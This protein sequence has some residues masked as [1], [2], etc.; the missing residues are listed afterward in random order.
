MVGHRT[1]L[2]VRRVLSNCAVALACFPAILPAG[3]AALPAPASPATTVSD[4]EIDA[5]LYKVLSV[6]KPGSSSALVRKQAVAELPLDDLTPDA[7]AKAEHLLQSLGLFRR[8]PTLAFDVEP[9]VYHYLLQNPDVAV[10]T[11]RAMEI[12]RFEL[13]QVSPGRYHADAGDGS[14]GDIEVWRSTRDDTLIY[15]DGAFKS[16][17]VIKPIVAR[18]I[19]RLRTR[20]VSSDDGTPRAECTGDVFVEFPSP[21]VETIAKVISPISHSIADRN[22]KQLSV[23]AHLMS[24][25]MTRQ[26][27]WVQQLARR[28]DASD[29]QKAALLQL[30][31]QVHRAAVDRAR[32][33][34]EPLPVDDIISPLRLP[35]DRDTIIPASGT[36]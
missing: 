3:E 4:G 16:P 32:V 12:S 34:R 8:L 1:A 14:V 22:F 36:N 2:G 30:T 7:R 17:L 25:A 29:D 9:G 19:M 20:I 11:W 5:K 35:N 13:K 28:M 15:C 33:H 27:A 31:A 18:S 24:Q 26:P 21:A 23:Y 6:V 10:S